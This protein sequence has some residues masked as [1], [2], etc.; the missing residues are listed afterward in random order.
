MKLSWRIFWGLLWAYINKI[1]IDQTTRI[2]QVSRPTVYRWYGLFRKNLPDMEE[3]RLAGVVQMDEAY[4]GKKKSGQVAII[5]AKSRMSKLIAAIVIPKASVAREDIVP[6]IQ[7]HVI[8]GA[9]LWTDGA[10]IYRGIGKHWPVE[11]SYDVHRKGEFGQTSEIE[12]FWGSFRTYIRRMYHHVTNAKLENLLL[13]YQHRLM[14]PE[15]FASPAS[16][17]TK[18]LTTVSFA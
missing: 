4:F 3:V 17:L 8:P 10:A 11:H 15:T 18:T 14:H 7:Q 9:K 5:G 2:L 1:P 12:G 13:E 6:F 16:F